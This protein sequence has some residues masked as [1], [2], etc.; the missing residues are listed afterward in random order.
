MQP[1]PPHEVLAFLD[2]GPLC[3]M[4]VLFNSQL[5]EP[6]QPTCAL[7]FVKVFGAEAKTFVRNN[8]V[9]KEAVQVH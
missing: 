8:P 9:I 7:G 3:H 6:W 4:S 5:P 1:P 2:F